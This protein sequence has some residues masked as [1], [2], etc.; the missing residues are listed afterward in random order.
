MDLPIVRRIAE[1]VIGP[2]AAEVD[3][4]ARF[5]ERS[6]AAL[7]SERLLGALVPGRLGGLGATLTDMANV[8]EILAEHCA[9]TALIYAMHQIQVH[10]LIRH[11]QRSPQLQSYLT[12]L[13]E[14]QFL[15]ASATTESGVGGDLRTSMC[16]IMLEGDAFLLEKNAPVI[17]YGVNPVA[18]TNGIDTRAVQ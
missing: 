6:L 2:A 14:Q 18:E 10:C 9:S 17:S 3:L 13:S 4:T 16:S 5:P 12:R 7:K 1:D 15:L 8:C 11:S